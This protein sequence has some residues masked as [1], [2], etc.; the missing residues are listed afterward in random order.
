MQLSDSLEASEEEREWLACHVTPTS[1]AI[2]STSQ[3]PIHFHPCW[4]K[5]TSSFC[6]LPGTSKLRVISPLLK[7]PQLGIVNYVYKYSHIA[8]CISHHV[9]IGSPDK[10]VLPFHLSSHSTPQSTA[11]GCWHRP[12]CLAAIYLPAHVG[13]SIPEHT[14]WFV[15]SQTCFHHFSAESH[16]ARQPNVWKP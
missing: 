8:Q 16:S 12:S 4:S 7:C 5:F 14:G 2:I 6:K 9:D 13:P 15:G 11:G 3:S 1:V 10:Q